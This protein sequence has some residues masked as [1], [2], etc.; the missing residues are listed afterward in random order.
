MRCACECHCLF[1]LACVRINRSASLG[2]FAGLCSSLPRVD[3]SSFAES[4]AVFKDRVFSAG[5]DEA[6]YK[7]LSDAGFKT[8]SKFAFSSSYTP[9]AVD[10]SAFVKT[11]KEILKRDANLAEL[12]SFRRLLHEA[13]SLVTA[14]MKQQLER[15][16]EVHARKLTQPERADLYARQVERL[17]GLSLKGPLE[18]SD[19]LVD[20]FCSMYE[21]NRLRFVPWEKYTA[22]ETEL[23]KDSKPE[24]MFS[25]DG[26]GKLR[27]ESKKADA[28]ADTSTEILLQYALQR[29]GLSM[30]QSNLLE[31]N[32]HQKWVDRVIKIRLTPS[33]PGYQLTSF[34]Q[35]LE[36][37]NKLFEEL[38]DSTRSGVQVTATGRPLD[39]C[40]ENCMNKAEVMH[41]LQPLPSKSVDTSG[42]GKGGI[43]FE[44][45]SPYSEDPRKGKGKGKKGKQPFNNT[46]M[47]L[48]LVQGGCRA[49]TNG[50][51]P[52]C[53]GYNLGTCS[54]PVNR[55]RCDK[56][57]HVCAVPKCGKHHPFSQCPVK[58]DSGS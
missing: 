23:D 36:A 7:A 14:E 20:A 47:P 32:I 24:H 29:R 37:D 33:P 35:I 15:S 1:N 10:E 39:A 22:K 31:F 3:M 34:R 53:F 5:L 21:S 13:F 25:V 52:I 48:T 45:P 42:A 27:I 8:L 41:L 43:V 55:G 50:G 46:K 40:F 28:I 16:E 54:L 6:V 57:F 49:K 9:G 18:A 17:K 4:E 56:G 2:T 26:S 11:V 38:C 44:R 30:D 58:K 51:D 19:A 12:A